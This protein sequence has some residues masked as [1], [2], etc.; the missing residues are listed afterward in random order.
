LIQAGQG[1]NKN[2][3]VASIEFELVG[4]FKNWSFYLIKS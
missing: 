2:S 3:K 4:V 1:R